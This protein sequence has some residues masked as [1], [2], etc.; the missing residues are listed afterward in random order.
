MPQTL[1]VETHFTPSEKIRDIDL[2]PGDVP[3]AR[4][5]Q[6]KRAGLG[7]ARHPEARRGSAPTH[8]LNDPVQCPVSD[9]STTFID[10]A[11]GFGHSVKDFFTNLFSN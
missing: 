7:P 3:A 1:H 8:F 2:P 4:S 10:S 5:I 11:V 6:G 9:G